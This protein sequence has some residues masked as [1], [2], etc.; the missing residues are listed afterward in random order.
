MESV[1]GLEALRHAHS[2]IGLLVIQKQREASERL[3]VGVGLAQAQKKEERADV[4]FCRTM[5]RSRAD[6]GVCFD[7]SS[8][9]A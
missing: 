9:P 5:R 2:V 3:A 8:A 1:E 4:M 6:S 7:D